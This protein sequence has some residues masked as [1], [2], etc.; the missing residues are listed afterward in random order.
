MAL[1]EKI[2]DSLSGQAK[3]IVSKLDL[4]KSAEEAVQILED[5]KIISFNAIDHDKEIRKN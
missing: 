3:H 1:I 4:S 2:S 5:E